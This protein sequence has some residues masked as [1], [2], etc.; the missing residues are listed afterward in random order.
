MLAGF[1][2]Q[3]EMLREVTAEVEDIKLVITHALVRGS[4][5]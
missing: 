5:P 2:P 3:D 4:N 1:N